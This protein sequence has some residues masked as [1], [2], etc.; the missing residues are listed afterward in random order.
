M[1]SLKYFA[2]QSE[3]GYPIPSTMMGFKQDPPAGLLV[4]IPA[5]DSTVGPGQSVSAPNSGLRY[6]VRRDAR[7][8]I[9]PNSL[10][11]TVNKPKGLVYEFK[12][13]T[14]AA[15]DAVPLMTEDGESLVSEENEELIYN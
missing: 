4:E 13:I 10:M 14:G 7:G 8:N 15:V 6:F 11:A 2:Q 5:T 1:A 9:I 12:V 3:D